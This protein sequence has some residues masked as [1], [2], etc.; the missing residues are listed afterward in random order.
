[1][2]AVCGLILNG[3]MLILMDPC[4][5]SQ[6]YWRR[7]SCASNLKQV[8]TAL[9]MYEQDYDGHLPPRGKWNK[10][11]LDSYKGTT[12]LICPEEDCGKSTYAINR[13]VINSDITKIDDPDG[14]IMLYECTPG[15]NRV[16]GMETAEYRH[17]KGCNAGFLDGHVKWLLEKDFRE[18][19]SRKVETRKQAK[20]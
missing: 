2:M 8:N 6:S 7:K 19:M 5:H 16:G 11:V 9:A 17:Y 4:L 15:E 1:M 10:V 18:S 3:L 13:D 12:V 20:K 14:T